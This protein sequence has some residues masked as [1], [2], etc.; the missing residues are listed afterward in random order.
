MPT[1][2]CH[3]VA[4]AVSRSA[5]GNCVARLGILGRD[6]ESCLKLMDELW[7]QQCL[8]IKQNCWLCK[9]AAGAFVGF[10]Y[11]WVSNRVAVVMK[12]QHGVVLVHYHR[13]P[14]R[15]QCFQCGANCC[16]PCCSVL[17]VVNASALV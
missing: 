11:A 3:S 7:L 4:V 2:R 9:P 15:F 10:K 6:F 14:G 12:H 5:A 8:I 13:G 16:H 1:G 17:C